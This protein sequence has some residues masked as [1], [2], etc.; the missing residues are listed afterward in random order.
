[1]LSPVKVVPSQS[2]IQVG[3][4]T[5]FAHNPRGSRFDYK[6]K[7]G[8]CIYKLHA[9]GT[10]TFAAVSQKNNSPEDGWGIWT[11]QKVSAKKGVLKLN[12]EVWNLTFTSP[13]RAVAKVP[14]KKRTYTCDFEWL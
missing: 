1:M 3:T 2:P 14:G 10:Y 7:G 12:G 6:D 9:N 11:Y 13:H 4:E 5:S 8:E